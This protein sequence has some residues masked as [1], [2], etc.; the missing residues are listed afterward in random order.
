MKRFWF[1]LL[2]VAVALI[3]GGCAGKYNGRGP[4]EPHAYDENRSHAYNLL[5]STTKSRLLVYDTPEGGKFLEHPDQVPPEFRSPDITELTLA[6]AGSFFSPNSLSRFGIGKGTELGVGLGL[7]I[8]GD[9]AKD[10]Q[11]KSLPG[12]VSAVYG[13]FPYEG[14]SRDQARQRLEDMLLEA[15]GRL[16]AEYELP[17]GFYFGDTFINPW[18]GE[19][20]YGTMAPWIEVPI[21]GESPEGYSCNED[22]AYF[23]A[24]MFSVYGKAWV[25]NTTVIHKGYYPEENGGEKAWVVSALMP[26]IVWDRT[27]TKAKDL[28]DQPGD[29]LPLADLSRSL[30]AFL[31]D[32]FFV[33]HNPYGAVDCLSFSTP[34]REVCLENPVVFLQGEAQ[35]FTTPGI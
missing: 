9:I 4:K 17:E 1:L 15:L 18:D 19:R 10:A 12:A 29:I 26:R 31:P 6:G 28:T 16:V 21:Y 5:A 11:F 33:Y 14:L 7:G 35:P 25:P 27:V 34:E 24:L 30:S 20:L 13:F 22:G 8:L 23:C 32:D 2:V 3:S